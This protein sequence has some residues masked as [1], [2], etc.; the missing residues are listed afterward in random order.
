M[1]AAIM[2]RASASVA[3]IIALVLPG[4]ALAQTEPYPNRPVRMIAPAAPGG[5]PD[6]LGRLLAQKFTDALGKPFVVENIPGA[7]GVVAANM[8]AK[9]PPDGH[10]LMLADSGALAINPAIN[11]NTSYHPLK[12]F[13]A[14][15]AVATLPTAFVVHPGV[16]ARTPAEFIA[17]AKKDPGKLTYGSAGPGSI[18]HLTMAA[19]ADSAGIEMLHVPYR[20]GSAMVNA[21]LAGEIQAGWSGIP[22]VLSLIESGKLRALCVSIL[23]RSK[24]LPSVPTC[25]E[26]GQRGFNIATMLGLLAPA[27]TPQPIVATLQAETAKALR[28][29]KMAER[30]V[31]LGVVMQENGTAHYQNYLRDD[32]ERYASI[33]RKL[34]LQIK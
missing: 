5:N 18:H 13:A 25:D 28:D 22:N 3:L 23:E 17:L 8:V 33:V 6:V 19:F 1:E 24:S 15:T 26:R 11:P 32:M 10:V 2:R 27:G 30:M 7:G 4:S 29:P 9:S 21:L 12:D 31:Q 14:I 16:A 34:N 20:G